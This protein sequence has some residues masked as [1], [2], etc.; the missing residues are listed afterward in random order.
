MSKSS[1]SST[2][3][4]KVAAGNYGSVPSS[5]ARLLLERTVDV[6]L[7]EAAYK[8]K[9]LKEYAEEGNWTWRVGGFIA[10]LSITTVSVFSFI[11]NFFTLS[12]LG[13]LMDVYLIAFGL[14]ACALEFKHVAMTAE[15]RAAMHREALF[16]YRPYGRAAF[17]F[18]VGLLEVANGGLLGFIVG[19]YTI[20]VGVIIY[21]ASRAALASLEIM[22]G[23]MKSEKDVASY[24]ALYDVD[25]TGSLDGPEMAKLCK[26]LGSSATLNELESALMVLD[27]DADGKVSYE[28]FLAWWQGRDDHIV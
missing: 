23:T 7:T 19:A 18:F 4:P 3:L 27:H 2:E 6:A 25:G 9:E 20:C 14:L 16:L 21:V 17:Y 11:A 26:A 13:A 24:F 28:E 22:R 15:F 5:E 12:P 10:G 8:Y 1:N